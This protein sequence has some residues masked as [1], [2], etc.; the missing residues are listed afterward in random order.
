MVEES[1]FPTIEKRG[2]MNS[3]VG[4][5]IESVRKT[6]PWLK[7]LLIVLLFISTVAGIFFSTIIVRPSAINI[8]SFFN[9]TPSFLKPSARLNQTGDFGDPVVFRGK[10]GLTEIEIVCHGMGVGK[11]G[12]SRAVIDGK[13]VAPGTVIRGMKIV[14]IS[15]SNILV[16]CN[17][18]NFR[19]E[20]GERVTPE[21]SDESQRPAR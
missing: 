12:L 9:K 19:L 7:W 1:I 8:P 20:P 16:S 21:K 2:V 14:E 10:S 5:G 11:D 6:P 18:G 4:R 15:A 17:G 13:I 3:V